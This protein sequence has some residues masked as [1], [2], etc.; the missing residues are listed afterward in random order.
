MTCGSLV[1]FSQ[2]SSYGQTA[3]FEVI[4]VDSYEE[5]KGILENLPEPAPETFYVVSGITASIAK[6][7]GREDC[8]SPNKLVR[9]VDDGSRVL[10]CLSLRK[11]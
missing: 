2:E 4:P 11:P 9:D 1:R 5:E 10:G 6:L 7:H 8:L 3:C